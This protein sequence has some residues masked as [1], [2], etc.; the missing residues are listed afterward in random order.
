MVRAF[1]GGVVS[2][3][4]TSWTWFHRPSKNV[5]VLLFPIQSCPP[6]R[7]LVLPPISGHRT[8]PLSGKVG[9]RSNNC[10]Q[11]CVCLITK[12]A[13]YRRIITPCISHLRVG[14]LMRLSVHSHES[15]GR[16]KPF[17]PST[18]HTL[19]PTI[20]SYRQPLPY[21]YTSLIVYIMVA[22]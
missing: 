2:R 21:L 11:L 14:S 12:H 4:G 18:F 15:K 1:L 16:C 6:T 5:V 7:P 9:I 8:I 20:R 13:I 3:L 22:L 10:P 19:L 17:L